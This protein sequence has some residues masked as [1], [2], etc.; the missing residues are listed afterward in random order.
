M[1]QRK[2]LQRT[3]QPRLE[4]LVGQYPAVFLTGPRQSGKTTLARAT[5]PTFAYRSLEDLQN[6]GEAQEDPRGFLRRFESESGVILD[7]VQRVPELF[8]YLQSVLDEER[9][10][11]FVLTGSQHFLLSE[12]ISQSLAGR[13]A[14]LE[15]L[16]LSLAEL[17]GRPARPPDELGVLHEPDRAT[18]TSAPSIS[19]DQ[20]LFQGLYPRIHD[21]GLESGP[22]L[23]AYVRTY[24]E[25]DVRMVSNIG[26]LDTFVRFVT[27]CAGRSGQVLNYS[28]L[29]ADAGVAQPTAKRWISVLRAGYILDLLQPYHRNFDKR[30]V[31]SPK[32]FLVDPGLMCHLLGLR[33]VDDLRAHPLRGS[34]FETFVLAELRKLFVYHGER[35]PLYYWRDSR[36]EI[37]ALVDFGTR[38]VPI[39]VKA[40]ETLGGDAFRGLH[41]LGELTGRPNGLVV[42]G[43]EESYPRGEFQIRSWR[44]IT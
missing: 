4:S 2:I 34:I 17:A 15:L 6:R 22:W 25:R 41:Y 30:L 39:E 28:S 1:P 18:S 3:L 8:S 13:V 43:G 26:D 11:P 37:D 38:L 20:I 44:D 19:L 16:P 33:R 23:D 35:P 27:L 42:Y 12:K 40:G 5:F 10:G 31:K 36:L 24:V 32:L 29:A 21:R 7:E 14:I 9:A